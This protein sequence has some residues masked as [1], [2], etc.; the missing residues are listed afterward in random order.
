MRDP[1]FCFF[2]PL[3]KSFCCGFISLQQVLIAIAIAD[4]TMGI[5]SIIIG[6]MLLAHKNLYFGISASIGINCIS[7]ILGIGILFVIY[8]QNIRL[9]RLYFFWK[10]V[11]VF[12][13][14]LF[15]IL[16]LV[17]YEGNEDLY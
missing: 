12:L 11:E 15:E 8:K 7:F 2:I 13:I 4:I 6:A 14:P 3:A 16:I 9:L 10:C 1:K 5:V 17:S